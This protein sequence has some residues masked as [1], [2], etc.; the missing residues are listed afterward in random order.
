MNAVKTALAALTAGCTL[1]PVTPAAA[2]DAVLIP[3]PRPPETLWLQAD[4]PAFGITIPL[5]AN[6]LTATTRRCHYGNT[7]SWPQTT[8]PPAICGRQPVSALIFTLPP[9]LSATVKNQKSPAD[10]AAVGA[11]SAAE[12]PTEP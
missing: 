2:G 4:A 9:S 6:S 3:I 11:D 8:L 10:T 5:C 7:K 1:L 12:K